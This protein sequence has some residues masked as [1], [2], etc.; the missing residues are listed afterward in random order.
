M[1][2][3]MPLIRRYPL[4]RTSLEG[5]AS[6]RLSFQVA[7]FFGRPYRAPTSI[8]HSTWIRPDRFLE[9]LRCNCLL[10]THRFRYPT[11][12]MYRA[13]R[14][15]SERCVQSLSTRS[16]ARQS[17]AHSVSVLPS[18][19]AVWLMTKT[20]TFDSFPGSSRNA[21]DHQSA[22]GSRSHAGCLADCVE[23]FLLSTLQNFQIPL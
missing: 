8:H 12:S 7:I 6:Y 19:E 15:L 1:L 20:S 21:S 3:R 13:P 22:S 18:M 14:D 17:P 10:S 9:I 16:A 4:I 2:S 5:F 23:P 11:R